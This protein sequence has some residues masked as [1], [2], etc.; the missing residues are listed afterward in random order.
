MS[1]VLHY[2]TGSTI[3]LEVPPE[4]LVAHCHAPRDAAIDDP[5]SAVAAALAQ[6]LEYPPLA[7]ATV[8]GDRVAVVLADELPQ[9]PAIV[10]GVVAALLQ[11]GVE[12]ANIVLLQSRQA[13][14]RGA[15]DP[16][17]GLARDVAAEVEYL[18]HDPDDRPALALLGPSSRNE[19]IYLNRAI[20]EADL[21]L[22]V[23]VL[24]LQQAADYRGSYASLFPSFSGK[25]AQA[26]FRGTGY[27][28]SSSER[29]RRKK[30]TEE[31]GWLLGARLMVQI[32]PG[33]GET[34]QHVVAGDVDAVAA[35]AQ[36]LGAAL[37]HCRLPRRASLV[38]ASI[39]GAAAQ[40]NWESVARALAAALRAVSVEGGAIALCTDLATGPGPALMQL[41]ETDDVE[42]AIEEIRHTDSGD[43]ESAWQLAQALRRGAV[44]LLSQLNEEVVESLG[45]AAVE[46][47]SLIGRLPQRFDSCIVLSNAQH[48]MP[49]VEF[50]EEQDEDDED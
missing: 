21:V 24:R 33:A 22:P 3:E 17:G 36:R 16:R 19:G 4:V 37:W 18:V 6:P 42:A 9:V 14:E 2:G 27:L 45:M 34:I 26:R 46:Q 50:D 20:C 12:P 5:A 44:F 30:E 23:S 13:V 7:V 10:A 15:A 49:S 40:Q 38:V 29:A 39:E 8:P 25:T 11:A 41:A 43:V 1:S 31:V 32:V 28:E 35:E 47:P 48:A